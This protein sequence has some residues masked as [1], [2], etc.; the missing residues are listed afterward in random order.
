MESA[1][2][3]PLHDLVTPDGRIVAF[4]SRTP[5]MAKVQVAIDEIPP[6]FVGYRIDPDLILFNFKSTLAQLGLNGVMTSCALDPKHG[7]AELDI[8]L[9]AIT[10]LAQEIL[11]LLTTGAYIG[12]LFAADDR[13]RVR[14]PHY[15][16]RM[17]G[18]CDR[19]GLPLL[20]FGGPQHTNSLS[21]KRIDGRT[22]AHI[23]LEQGILTYDETIRGLLPT[24][25]VALCDSG[26][27]IRD[28]LRLHQKHSPHGK[29][30]AGPGEV[31]LVK[32]LP[33]YIR[34]VFGRVVNSL[35]PKGLSHTTASILQPDTAASGDVYELFGTASS[36]LTE[37]PLEFYTLEP[38]RE[39][40]F[41]ADR[42]QLQIA[43]EDDQTLFHAFE[44]SPSPLHHLADTFVVKGQQLLSLTPTDWITREGRFQEFPGFADPD[45]QAAMAA[46]YIERQPSYPFLKAI[47]TNR[48]TSEGIL[49][50][51]YFPSPLMKQMCLSDQVH[52]LLKGIYFQYPSRT[53]G[54]FF[55]HEDRSFLLDLAK[56]GIP[57]YWVD[58]AS[59][60]V[61]QYIPKPG[62]DSGM[63]VPLDQVDTFLR[64][65]LF[66]IYGSNLLEFDVEAPLTHLLKGI[67]A[68]AL[69]S[70]HPLLNPDTPIAL[71]T[72][73]GPGAMSLGNRVAKSLDLLSCANIMDFLGKKGAVINEQ[74]QNPFI[75]AKM[76]YR[77]DRLVER[78]GEFNL[79]F[80]I[81]LMGGM[82]TDFEFTLEAVR[83]KIGAMAPTPVLLFGA[84]SY[85][86]E[87]VTPSFQC[88]LRTGTI[89]GSEWV[90]NCF[91]AVKT[92]EEGLSVYRQFFR[93]TLKIGP[94]GPIYQDGFAILKSP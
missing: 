72:G 3:F 44:S 66:G 23:A 21:L 61:L 17:F 27:K 52:R 33:L 87:K 4:S 84:P 77:L 46:S 2:F 64:A 80:P 36:E 14:D 7:R 6:S 9:E 56:F 68:L 76:T 67:I 53:Y 1:L 40:V 57:A 51:R 58:L 47:E 55:S 10:P 86:K 24:L 26:L 91:Y 15:L 50:S 20:S 34:T 48:I 39:Y 92:A 8:S 82:G 29:R 16:S 49:L 69:E 5:E 19:F 78:Q 60:K 85:W 45:K 74:K 94:T 81:F 28:L 18:R 35:L 22:V 25:A 75:D 59:R 42:D 63:F 73:G 32:T 30:R 88:N 62:K 31:L 41:F 54:D 70:R 43:L 93:G 11:S 90:S 12:K 71:V 89:H 65:T 83:R 37:I 38:Y 13:R 79:D